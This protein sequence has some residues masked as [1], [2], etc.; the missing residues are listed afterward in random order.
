[1]KIAVAIVLLACGLGLL[2]FK[3]NQ[4]VVKM[5]LAGTTAK[6]FHELSYNAIDGQAQTMSQFAGKY[7]M[8]VNVASKCGYTP[9]YEQLEKLYKQM[10]GKLVIIGFPCNQFLG[11][12]PGSESEIVEFC[13][14]NYGVTFPLASKIDVKGGAQHPVYTWLT[15]KSLNLKEDSEVS[16]NFHKY[17]IDPD[18]QYLG[19]FGSRVDPMDSSILS[20][21]PS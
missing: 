9:Q 5:Q 13:Q 4:K 12:E 7:I 18:G 16:W 8:I 21:L 20:L 1:M 2:A 11:Q 3:R 17:L 19:H 10:N 15:S 6:N 14:K